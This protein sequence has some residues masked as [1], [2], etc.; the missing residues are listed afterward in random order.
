MFAGISLHQLG[1]AIHTSILNAEV[2]TKTLLLNSIRELSGTDLQLT[3]ILALNIS[4]LHMNIP[5]GIVTE[6]P[7]RVTTITRQL[8]VYPVARA[9]FFAARDCWKL[10][11]SIQPLIT[12]SNGTK[13]NLL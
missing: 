11:S 9:H 12:S 8:Q 7:L 10:E 5:V 13:C 3:G 1:S 2:A 6:D 4:S